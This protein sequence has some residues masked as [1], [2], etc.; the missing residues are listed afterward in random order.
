MVQVVDI[1]CVSHM[2][3]VVIFSSAS[4]KASATAAGGMPLAPPIS[5]ENSVLTNGGINSKTLTEPDDPR[6]NRKDCV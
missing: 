2:D 4:N 5:L 3:L 6:V 1:G